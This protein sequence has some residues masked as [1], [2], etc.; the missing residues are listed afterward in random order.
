MNATPADRGK[1]YDVFIS[2]SHAADGR[3]AP[4][5][6]DGLR[7]L[8]RPWNRRQAL[9]VFRDDTG[10]S[11]TPALW[12]AIETALLTSEYFLFL[13]SPEAARSE[14]VSREI[15]SWITHRSPE[16]LLVALTD[17]NWVWD[18]V[19]GDLD[20]ERSTAAPVALRGVFTEESQVGPDGDGGRSPQH[21][22]PRRHRGRSSPGSRDAER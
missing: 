4:A 17:G 7:K 10:L 15:R 1:E 21:P 14:W 16:R 19:R 12:P 2:Y 22:V 13:A 6:Q 3:L 18:A 8:A 5:V 9:R 20:F 11:V